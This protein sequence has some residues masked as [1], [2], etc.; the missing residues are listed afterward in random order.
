MAASKAS[1]DGCGERPD[2]GW[3]VLG[4]VEPGAVRADLRVAQLGAAGGQ[5]EVGGEGV[6]GRVDQGA[7]AGAVDGEQPAAVRGW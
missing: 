7:G 1:T 6:G 5:R 2:V 3:R 4:H